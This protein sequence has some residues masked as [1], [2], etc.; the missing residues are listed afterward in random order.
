MRNQ[1]FTRNLI[2]GLCLTLG[3]SFT[4]QA[5]SLSLSSNPLFLTTGAE[6]N[7]MFVLDDSGS[8]HWEMMPDDYIYSYFVYPRPSGVYE[9]SSNY[10]NYV[11]AFD[12][13]NPYNAAVRAAE[14]NRIYYNPAITYRP[15]K[16]SD[17][18]DYPNAT[19][20]CAYHNPEKTSVGCRD[21]TANNTESAYWETCSTNSPWTGC[22]TSSLESRTFWPA[23][24]YTYN[25]G[26]IWNT[27]N[28]T[29][30]DITS[31]TATYSSSARSTRTDCAAAPSC[32]YAEEIQNFANW[33]TYYRSRILAARA[34]VGRAFAEQ[35][36]A[37]RVGFGAINKGSS[38]ID[39]VSTDTIV[40]GVRS[41]SGTNRSDF[42]NQLYQY[43][44][45]PAM[46]PLRRGLDSAG[47]YF[48]RSDSLSPWSTTPGTAG[49][50]NTECRQSF[51]ILMTDGYWNDAQAGTS[52][53]RNNNDGTAGPTI[54]GPLAPPNNTHTYSA[55]SP[56]TDTYS[57]TLADVAM[58]YW[59]NDLRT[60]MAN[61]VPPSTSDPAF[62]QHMT[63]FGIGLGVSGTVD[64]TTAF[65]AIGTGATISWPDPITLTGYERLDDLLH[66]SI[67]GHGGFFS[68]ADPD[69]F[70]NNL[71]NILQ[72]IVSRTESSFSSI[73][74]N[75]TRLNTETLVYQARFDSADWSGR[76]IAYPLD[77]AG[78]LLTPR[79]DTNFGSLIPLPSSRRIFTLD[80][81]GNGIALTS[82]NFG[83]L[84]ASQQLAL[85]KK[86]DGTVDGLGTDRVRWLRGETVSG[87][88]TRTRLLGDIINSDPIFV[89]AENYGYTSLPLTDGGGSTYI[90]FLEKKRER[91]QI[92][93]FG[94]NDG[95]LHAIDAKTGEELFAYTPRTLFPT[96]SRLTDPKYGKTGGPA[97]TSYVDGNIGIGDAYIDTG[98]GLGLRWRTILVGTMGA[99]GKGVFALDITELPASG[100]PGAT[101]VYFDDSKVLWEYA[102]ADHADIGNIYSAPQIVQLDD[103]HWVAVFGNGY[104]STNHK[105]KLFAI[106]LA[107]GALHPD[108]PLDT[109]VGSA[110]SQNGLGPVSGYDRGTRVFGDEADSGSNVGDGFYA[111]D[112]LGNVWRFSKGSS[113][114]VAYGSTATPAPLFIAR[115]SS[116]NLQPITAPIEIGSP[117]VAGDGVM[118]FLGTGSY[119]LTGDNATSNLQSLY[120]L[121]DKGS[122]ISGRSDLQQQTIVYQGVDSGSGKTVRAVSNTAVTYSG[123]GAKRGWYLDLN[124]PSGERVVTIP[125]LRHGRVVFNTII[126]T[127][128]PCIGGGESWLLELNQTTGGRLDYSVFDINGDNLFNSADYINIGGG[129]RVP[130]SGVKGNVGITK[131]PAWLS[132]GETAYK[133]QSGT[134]M[135]GGIS[136]TGASGSAA[137]TGMQITKN[138]GGVNQPRTSWRQLFPDDK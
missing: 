83:S 77:N 68:A 18:T 4:Q 87:M 119:F 22:T 108:F 111:G 2:L 11:V 73:A 112:L 131:S 27:A 106:K 97:H 52:A 101:S 109:K 107:N 48:S 39:G 28:Y 20:S 76:M 51:T 14:V 46:T 128:N 91:R 1:Q 38:T 44:M 5:R 31:S 64:P 105:A 57:N 117:P 122:T 84:S 79:W 62:W 82:V 34:G 42:F 21:L 126:P 19:P 80:A 92:L 115:D 136:V 65:A 110:A 118:L 45:E 50:T 102:D 16:R 100:S 114:K 36:E 74:A 90:D 130:A 37:M 124:N 66:A 24:Y 133:I 88:R 29:R 12:A 120:G 104:N 134:D 69:T 13:A 59:K 58:Y 7:V 43:H 71:S 10:T 49:G 138:K 94:S 81:S 113:W 96:L 125:L 116:S 121:W 78:N 60:D 103:G 8:M 54:T 75:S 132:G 47:K 129:V 61:R 23:I 127:T 135:Y 33:Y 25:G 40:K 17:N 41:F 70:A 56:Y 99:G 89:G 9:N 6:P 98:D 35:P 53:A 86:S 26:G 32:T 63:T 15:W 137:A 3:L 72:D 123:G 95:M 30:T 67:N 55:V 93:Y 85:N